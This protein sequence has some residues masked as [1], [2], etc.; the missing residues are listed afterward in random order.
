MFFKGVELLFDGSFAVRI[1]HQNGTTIEVGM[2]GLEAKGANAAVHYSSAPADRHTSKGLFVGGGGATIPGT[3]L[4]FAKGAGQMILK[5]FYVSQ[6][7][8]VAT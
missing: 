1:P 8:Q 2:P 3:G 5:R 4:T 7:K 6:L